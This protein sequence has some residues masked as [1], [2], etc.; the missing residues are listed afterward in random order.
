M[1]NT[2][3]LKIISYET[4]FISIGNVQWFVCMVIKLQCCLHIQE[5][6]KLNLHYL[7]TSIGKQNKRKFKGFVVILHTIFAYFLTV[8]QLMTRYLNKK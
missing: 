5:N 2:K 7:P 6:V 8:H 4:Q 1:A 3:K